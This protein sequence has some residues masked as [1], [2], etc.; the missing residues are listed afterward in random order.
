LAITISFFSSIAEFKNYVEKSI[1]ETKTS[2]G[3][4]LSRTEDIRRRYDK[5]RKH[6]ETLKKLTGG[7][8]Q[9]PKDTKQMEVGG[10]KVLVNPTAEYELTLMEETVSTLQDKLDAFEKAK[11]MFPVLNDEETKIGVVLNEGIPS[12]FMLYVPDL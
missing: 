6:F 7:K 5:S 12:G 4:H 1:T 8:Q 11:E 2:L 10:F 9:V 3:T